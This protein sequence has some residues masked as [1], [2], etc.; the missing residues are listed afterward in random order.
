[1]SKPTVTMNELSAIEALFGMQ[2]GYVL[3]FSN[4][5]FALFF[6]DFEID[7]DKEFPEGSKANRLRAFLR[8][9]EPLMVA[10]V[11]EELLE[12]RGTEG[13]DDSS[14]KIQKVRN[15]IAR[16]RGA[17]LSLPEVSASVDILNLTYIHEL[18]AKTNQRLSVSDL[19]GAITSARTMLEAV[20]AELER[21]LVV[22]PEDHK[23]DLQ[24]QY[25]AVA[26]HLRMD[27]SRT[28]LDDSFKQVVRGMVQIVNGLAPIRNR[29]SDGHPRTSKPAFHHARVIANASTTVATFLVE[30]YIYQRDNGLLPTSSPV[31]KRER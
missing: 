29:M 1:M 13:D 6:A 19:D 25:K 17:Q 9:A 28:E 5:S 31:P 3:D 15:L 22:I 2:S 10:N 18:E 14:F 30:S 12:R 20:L 16:L 24:R 11:L 27:E 26:K 4:R 21:Q 7:I 23:G 8:E